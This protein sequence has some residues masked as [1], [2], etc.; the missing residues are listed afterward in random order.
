MIPDGNAFD[1]IVSEG[2]I[3]EVWRGEVVSL[4]QQFGV[5]WDGPPHSMLHAETLCAAEP[6]PKTE[7]TN[8]ARLRSWRSRARMGALIF[9]AAWLLW[10]AASASIWM[11]RQW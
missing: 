11:S 2:V 8:T 7:A 9:V 1:V 5:N 3:V 6:Q 4:A 10:A